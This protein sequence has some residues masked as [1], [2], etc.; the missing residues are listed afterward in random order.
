MQ[1]MNE[2]LET[3]TLAVYGLQ[4]N[5]NVIKLLFKIIDTKYRPQLHKRLARNTERWQPT[6][7]QTHGTFLLRDYKQDIME[8]GTH[9]AHIHNMYI[10]LIPQCT[11]I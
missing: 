7:G 2:V 4:G 9:I 6:E 1:L 5:M 8:K 11:M 3:F 10:I